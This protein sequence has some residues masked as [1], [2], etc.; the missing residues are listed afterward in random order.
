[1]SLPLL[2]VPCKTSFK[3]KDRTTRLTA[4]SFAGSDSTAST[5]QSFCHHVLREPAI[6][7]RIKSELDEATKS[8][9]LSDFPQWN[10]VQALPFFQAC[11]K[12]AMRVRPA[13]GLNIT[14]HVPPEGAEIDGQRLP[15]G[16]RVALNGWVLHRDTQIF[17]SDAK[18]YRPQRWLED[19][20][21]AK[22]MERYMFQFGGGSHLCKWRDG[23]CLLARRTDC[24][25]GIGK[26][27][28]LL[29]MNKTLPLLFREYDFELLR[30][31]ED[32]KHNST[33]FVVQGGLDVKISKREKAM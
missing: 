1:M 27:L 31:Q 21:R 30:P 18:V 8:G 12:E 22:N 32:L 20:G 11:L 5:M 4:T 17:G 33:F 28:A 13:V 23:S 14:R 7:A 2:M 25:L 26:N 16:T 6:Y 9:K 3:F 19:E 10:E 24:A 15:G 29:E